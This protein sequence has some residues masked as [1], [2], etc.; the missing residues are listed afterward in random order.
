MVVV[1]YLDIL[2]CPEGPEELPENVLLSFRSEIVDKDAPAG[3]VGCHAGQQSVP[4]KEVA[5]QRRKPKR[6]ERSVTSFF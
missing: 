6:R 3:S 2:N 4:S 5:S 1:F